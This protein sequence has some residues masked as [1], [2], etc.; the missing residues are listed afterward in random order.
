MIRAS[1]SLLPL[2]APRQSGAVPWFNES[3][4]PFE[5]SDF[6]NGWNH[7]TIKRAAADKHLAIF[8]VYKYNLL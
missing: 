8:I 1:V 7:Y 5:I 3:G 4:N 6:S 2:P